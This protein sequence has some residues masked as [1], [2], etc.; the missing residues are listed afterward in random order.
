MYYIVFFGKIFFVVM[1]RISVK[2]AITILEK[3]KIEV[4]TD[5]AIIILDL[6]Y[7]IAKTYKKNDCGK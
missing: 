2:S 3:N 6:L 7:L 4:N 1:K 5:E